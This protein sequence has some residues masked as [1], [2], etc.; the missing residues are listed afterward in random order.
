MGVFLQELPVLSQESNLIRS[1]F[2]RLSACWSLTKTGLG[3]FTA[4]CYLH[5]KPLTRYFTKKWFCRFCRKLTHLCFCYPKEMDMLLL[6][7]CSPGL[8]APHPVLP[9]FLFLGWF[10]GFFGVGRGRD[11]LWC[12]MYCI[13]TVWWWLNTLSVRFKIHKYIYLLYQSVNKNPQ[14]RSFVTC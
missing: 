14:S 5:Y 2:F 9:S 4:F 11:F 3:V 8:W 1:K 13:E 6:L 12:P 10:C 7:V